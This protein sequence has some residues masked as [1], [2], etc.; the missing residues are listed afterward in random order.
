MPGD[1]AVNQKS[2]G[3]ALFPNRPLFYDL[4]GP[5]LDSR[6]AQNSKPEQRPTAISACIQAEA[7]RA[8]NELAV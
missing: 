8:L 1:N 7:A 5:N 3:H 4:R 6:A 2:D